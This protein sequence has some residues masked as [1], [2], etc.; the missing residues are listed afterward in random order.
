VPWNHQAAE[1]LDLENRHTVITHD[2]DH[3]T[4][5]SRDIR[6]PRN[7][8]GEQGREECH[9]FPLDPKFE[10]DSLIERAPMEVPEK[11]V[12]SAAEWVLLVVAVA[13]A[14]VYLSW[15]NLDW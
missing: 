6:T 4:G 2:R 8:L 10:T 12:P 5:R 14:L 13:M 3:L 15:Q 7:R 9:T 11:P 1:P